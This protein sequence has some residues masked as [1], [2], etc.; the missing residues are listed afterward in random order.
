LQEHIIEC[1]LAEIELRKKAN[2]LQFM[3]NIETWLNN[4]TWEDYSF[5]ITE[6]NKPK[7]SNEIRL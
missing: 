7:S 2:N 6:K 1:L 3:R 5:Y 4:G